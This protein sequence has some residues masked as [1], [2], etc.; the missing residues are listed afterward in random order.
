MTSHRHL[1]PRP[2]GGRSCSR[3]RF[4]AQVAGVA[5]W[6]I[7]TPLPAR[8]APLVRVAPPVIVRHAGCIASVNV[9]VTLAGLPPGT[10]VAAGGDLLETDEPDGDDDPCATFP[11]RFLRVPA[12]QPTS[13]LL[14]CDARVSALGLV[15]GAGPA[16]DETTSPDLVELVARV[17]LRNVV[18]GDEIGT[19]LSPARVAVSSAAL[20]WTPADQ[21]P[22]PNMLELPRPRPRPRDGASAPL[23]PRA[24]LP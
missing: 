9:L 3:R 5:G 17:W 10:R 2:P 22:S 8:A 4:L 18:A 23:P 7:V 19:W 13:L 6:A 11:A 12:A 15:K 24:C 14:S 21:G 16:A 20:A 1:L